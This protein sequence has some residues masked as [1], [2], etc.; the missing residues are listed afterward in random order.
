MQDKRMTEVSRKWS[1]SG[2]GLDAAESEAR[3]L[4]KK[5][6]FAATVDEEAG[7][8]TLS[9]D[10]FKAVMGKL[11]SHKKTAKS[12]KKSVFLLAFGYLAV[13][14]GFI[15]VIVGL[16][17]WRL[18][19]TKETR[20]QDSALVGRD[21]VTV[22]VARV[23]SFAQLFDLPK[24]S[25]STLQKIES[26][27]VSLE[28]GTEV[29]FEI[30]RVSKL[31]G[32]TRV[33]LSDA[34]GNGVDIDS[35]S[36]LAIVSIDGQL[37]RVAGLADNGRQL[38]SEGDARLYSADEFASLQHSQRTMLTAGSANVGKA[39]FALKATDAIIDAAGRDVSINGAVYI[40]GEVTRF[41][42]NG[43]A[44]QNDIAVLKNVTG[45]EATYQI[46]IN[47]ADGSWIYNGESNIY[48]LFDK[49]ENLSAC[50]YA[51]EEEQR[52]L[53]SDM[54]FADIDAK[55][56]NAEGFVA[57]GTDADNNEWIF[58]SKKTD[59][60][61]IN[62]FD[63]PSIQECQVA[64]REEDTVVT[65]QMWE[66]YQNL[67]Q[68]YNVVGCDT[69]TGEGCVQIFDN[70]TNETM[71]INDSTSSPYIEEDAE[72]D[73]LNPSYNRKYQGVGYKNKWQGYGQVGST[74]VSYVARWAYAYIDNEKKGPREKEFMANKPNYNIAFH[75]Y[76]DLIVWVYG[77]D[78]VETFIF[79]WKGKGGRNEI[80][81]S[82]ISAWRGTDWD[83]ADIMAMA[84]GS[85]LAMNFLGFTTVKLP[86]VGI[87]SHASNRADG[88]AH[89]HPGMFLYVCYALFNFSK[90]VDGWAN[91][92]VSW[93]RWC[94]P[95]YA[96]GHSLG[97]AA[98]ILFSH[99]YWWPMGINGVH[100]FGSFKMKDYRSYLQRCTVPGTTYCHEDDPVGGDLT[101]SFALKV[102]KWIINKIITAIIGWVLGF[103]GGWV[104]EAIGGSGLFSKIAGTI[105]NFFKA[106]GENMMGFIQ[107]SFGG[108][109][110]D[111]ILRFQLPDWLPNTQYSWLP[112][113]I[114]GFGV[115]SK[116][117][118][119]AS[120]FIPTF[121]W[122]G[123]SVM[124]VIGVFTGAN[125]FM[126]WGNPPGTHQYNLHACGFT[127]WST[128]V[129]G[130][131]SNWAYGNGWA[132]IGGATM[133][134]GLKMAL[135]W[136]ENWIKENTQAWAPYQ[137]DVVNRKLLREEW[138]CK[139]GKCKT[140]HYIAAKH[141]GEETGGIFTV[142]DFLTVHK[143]DW[144]CREMENVLRIGAVGGPECTTKGNWAL[145][146][147]IADAS[148]IDS[149][150]DWDARYRSSKGRLYYSTHIQG[151]YFKHL[152]KSAAIRALNGA[153]ALPFEIEYVGNSKA[154]K[155]CSGP[156]WCAQYGHAGGPTHPCS[157]EV[158]AWT[159]VKDDRNVKCTGTR[160]C[161]SG[162]GSTSYG[163]SGAS[164]SYRPGGSAVAMRM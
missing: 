153:D 100:T 75:N 6:T 48:Y 47:H 110:L 3:R 67:K 123:M 146:S 142:K 150:M 92:L 23:E 139:W 61:A 42:E 121:Y 54:G 105:G 111:N 17:N 43:R 151:N 156:T 94:P 56:C 145:A 103:I 89:L 34:A 62:Y 119:F 66:D 138:K 135:N 154:R 45:A 40:D 128:T 109:F 163:G 132:G 101:A 80:D 20:V 85:P 124:D 22:G 7:T 73:L 149:N 29:A 71:Y 162:S 117:W 11:G 133:E 41:D 137:H 98:A 131:Q 70:T 63:I 136:G 90:G 39:N 53:L 120:K 24:F 140:K 106:R 91:G 37:H 160:W 10:D 1:A 86:S 35:C 102:I 95:V 79:R 129:E 125:K 15:A 4:E 144:Y 126:I 84:M 114:F 99:L 8:V 147:T 65:P 30:T 51:S 5:G 19:A 107:E 13:T 27:A 93:C 96:T 118:S 21:G 38:A 16:V 32:S 116:I 81:H 78:S 152:V 113:D 122:K 83:W 44:V 28:D 36:T 127:E 148:E 143:I 26:L 49:E 33:V 155:R 46:K 134:F 87:V 9:K 88:E 161:S 130:W 25:V 159:G 141:C 82:F 104:M 12:A 14:I 59:F 60:N 97:G 77:S 50:G 108:T 31:P 58:R 72:R 158:P 157:Q 112:Q 18:E 57:Q 76:W 115:P 2:V 52:S 69:T 164:R 55:Q 64:N 68:S 74:E